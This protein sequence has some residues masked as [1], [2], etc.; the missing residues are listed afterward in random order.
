M[1]DT[2]TYYALCAVDEQ[3]QKEIV[4]VHLRDDEE[5]G[6]VLGLFVYGAKE[7]EA[8]SRHLA[9]FSIPEEATSWKSLSIELVSYEELLRFMD[10]NMPN[11]VI[12]DG[13]KKAAGSVFKGMLKSALGL[14]IKHPRRLPE[15]PW[16]VERF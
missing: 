16:K 8:Q 1:T 4:P 5:M 3:G 14:P 7:G 10:S 11:S 6:T 15:E 13:E 9:E 12:L 2:H